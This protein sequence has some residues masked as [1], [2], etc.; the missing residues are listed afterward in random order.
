VGWDPL[1]A[2]GAGIINVGQKPLQQSFGFFDPGMGVP[3]PGQEWILYEGRWGRTGDGVGAPPFKW[4]EG[5]FGFPPT[6]WKVPDQQSQ[7]GVPQTID[8]GFLWDEYSR[9]LNQVDFATVDWGDESG[10]QT[11]ADLAS[12]FNIQADHTYADPGEYIVKVTVVDAWNVWGGNVFKVTVN[13][14][15]TDIALSN[16]TVPGNMPVGT[17]VGTF[18]ATDPAL[19]AA[20]YLYEL[21]TGEGD[22]DND[23][24]T[25]SGDQLL[26]DEV[27]DYNVKN[28]YSI[29]V[30]VTDNGGMA[31][32]EAFAI[33]VT[34]NNFSIWLP[35][36]MRST[37]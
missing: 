4:Y 31:Y 3:M 21:V 28:S 30:Q 8:L 19:P 22:V 10:I 27:F 14:A 9:N 36:L 5:Q 12:G 26:T 20:P 35:Y 24:F 18:S 33:N 11:I 25:I 29:R 1:A 17:R 6:L 32:E 37:K 13:A 2:G 34:S 23:S 7:A 15:P 16:D